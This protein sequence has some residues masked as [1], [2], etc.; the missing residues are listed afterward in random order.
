[1][2][3]NGRM[4]AGEQNMVDFAGFAF[5]CLSLGKPTTVWDSGSS[6]LQK[7]KTQMHGWNF[8][9]MQLH[10]SMPSQPNYIWALVPCCRVNRMLI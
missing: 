9:F 7:K 1:M 2:M 4:A 10:Q 8:S 3:K 6:H 5:Q